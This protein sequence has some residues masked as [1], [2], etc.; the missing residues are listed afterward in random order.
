MRRATST[1]LSPLLLAVAAAPVF[2]DGRISPIAIA[3]D[4][5]DSDPQINTRDFKGHKAWSILWPRDAQGRELHL[6]FIEGMR[7]PYR[8]YPNEMVEF[9]HD[10][11]SGDPAEQTLDIAGRAEVIWGRDVFWLAI[12]ERA[13]MEPDRKKPET[14]ADGKLHRGEARR[15]CAVFTTDPIPR[16]GSLVGAYCRD[17]APGAQ[18]DEATARQWLED[19]D[20]TIVAP[21]GN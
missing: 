10:A 11:S 18:V 6:G 4:V 7:L 9:A 17:L 14:M 12:S 20:L 2:A 3:A 8:D 5:V 21:P 16:E 15:H 13:V 19:L 1:L